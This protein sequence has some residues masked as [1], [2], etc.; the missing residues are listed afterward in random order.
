MSV[1]VVWA[2]LRRDL[3]RFV[4]DRHNLAASLVRP[5]LW[6]IALGFGLRGA[7]SLETGGL[8]YLSFLVPGIAVMS[9]LF[10]STFAAISIVWDREFGFLKELLVAPVPRGAIVL[11]RMLSGA[12]LSILEAGVAILV[13]PIL[14]ARFSPLGALG[15][16]GVYLV[17][18][19]GVSALG[20]V[21]AA[22]MRSFEGFGGIVNFIIQPLFFFSGAFY[23]L[24]ALPA[25][26]AALVRLNPATYAV[27]AARGLA[28][29]VHRF[30]LAL[31]LAVVALVALALGG[32]ATRAFGKMQA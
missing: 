22:R 12:T 32:W 27:D 7:F 17:F 24:D 5:F 20:I 9:V 14:G 2:L 16:L 30:P 26:L 11:A 19:M 28:V 25:P 1:E 8:D 15:A 6:L 23:P 21:I 10:T 3:A 13:S 18:G 31:D 4:R 29:G